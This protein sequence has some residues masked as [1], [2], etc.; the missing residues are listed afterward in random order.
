MQQPK[1]QK[2][3][4]LM[5]ALLNGLMVIALFG[6]GLPAVTHTYSQQTR[7][8]VIEKAFQPNEPM[9]LEDV[10]VRGALNGRES[11]KIG[12]KFHGDEDWLKGLTVRLKNK[13]GKSIVYAEV[14]VYVPTSETEDKPIRL[15]LRYGVIPL[16]PSDTI[17]LGQS[18][19][20]SHGAS[21]TLA[22]SDDEYDQAKGILREKNAKVDF[23]R[24]EMRI[25]MVVFDDD[26]AWKNG[27]EI[28]RD[29]SNPLRWSVL[30]KPNPR[31]ALRGPDFLRKAVYRP[32]ESNSLLFKLASLN[33]TR[34]PNV[35]V[36]A[37]MDDVLSCVSWAGTQS[38][39]CSGVWDSCSFYSQCFV[40]SD[41][42][43]AP[44]RGSKAHTIY[45]L[46]HKNCTCTAPSVQVIEVYYSMECDRIADE[47]L[48]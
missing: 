26:S 45:D 34:T 35:A 13:S 48:V 36:P 27:R 8:R 22:L 30:E 39:V 6:L 18:K 33:S 12:T 16:S 21:V 20:I 5:R 14:Y 2:G 41:D 31:A 15:S 7:E 42:Y 10:Q 46:C 44:G 37:S 23:T 17:T 29:P 38:Y 47:S 40:Q 1:S 11:V 9:D 43:N 28:R 25:G 4:K 32:L 3:R 19:S 24:T